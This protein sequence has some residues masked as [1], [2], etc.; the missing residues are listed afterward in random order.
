[1]SSMEKIPLE[2]HFCICV[3]GNYYPYQDLFATDHPEF[4][5]GNSEL[6]GVFFGVSSQGFGNFHL[7]QYSKSVTILLNYFIDSSREI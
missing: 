6:R 7:A 4:P 5:S 2:H 1:M 3:E